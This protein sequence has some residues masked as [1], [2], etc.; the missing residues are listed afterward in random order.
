MRISILEENQPSKNALIDWAI[1]KQLIDQIKSAVE[2]GGYQFIGADYSSRVDSILNVDGKTATDIK[3]KILDNIRHS[4][5]NFKMMVDARADGSSSF[6]SIKKDLSDVHDAISAIKVQS[7]FF[8]RTD[9]KEVKNIARKEIERIIHRDV[10]YWY[11]SYLIAMPHIVTVVGTDAGAV[12][13]YSGHGGPAIMIRSDAEFKP[14]LKKI[15]GSLNIKKKVAEGRK[16]KRSRKKKKYNFP[17]Y[18]F[19]GGFFTA[20]DASGASASTASMGSNGGE[21]VIES[22]IPGSLEPRFKKILTDLDGFVSTNIGE[23]LSVVDHSITFKNGELMLS[24]RGIDQYSPSITFQPEKYID[25]MKKNIISYLERSIKDYEF[26]VGTKGFPPPSPKKPDDTPLS[27]YIPDGKNIRD[28]YRKYYWGPSDFSN[29]KIIVDKNIK[30]LNEFK[31][32]INLIKWSKK[33]QMPYVSSGS[34]FEG[35]SDI[36]S[37]NPINRIKDIINDI[38]KKIHDKNG[39]ISYRIY[40]A[41][42]DATINL[43]GDDNTLMIMAYVA[44]Q[45]KGPQSIAFGHDKNY[46]IL[47]QNMLSNVRAKQR[48]KQNTNENE[49]SFEL[50]TRDKCSYCEDAKAL[51]KK[52]GISFTEIK[53]TRYDMDSFYKLC[54]KYGYRPC[55]FPLILDV[56]RPGIKV[57][58]GGFTELEKH[59]SG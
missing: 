59:F 4:Q 50:H 49:M 42:N 46:D 29:H 43:S 14:F 23:N 24:G 26:F 17:G 57:L 16:K 58:I 52:R 7:S 39:F 28:D 40:C 55:T 31:K 3:N 45:F 56:S 44:H 2:I 54:E 5:V 35:E 30:N 48:T 9:P 22:S 19:G 13:I 25:H 34:W 10:L 51:L 37:T 27:F 38:A 18:A 6:D 21:S 41:T 47:K 15:E 32:N 8:N 33:D 53:Y 12:I 36:R 1:V 20:G 11:F